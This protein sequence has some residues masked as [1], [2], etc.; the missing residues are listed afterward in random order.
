MILDEAHQLTDEASNALLKTLEE[1]PEHVV[2]ILATTRAEDL[3]DTINR[4]RSFFIFARS[5]SRKSPAKSNASPR[6]KIS[7]SIPA[8]SPCWRAPPKA[9][10]RDG[11]SLLEQAIAYC[12]DAIT[13]TQVRE[14][15]G[16]VAESVLDDLVGA[17]AA[18]SAERALASF[19][20]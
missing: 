20:A 17:I 18:Q 14:L 11:L 1:P 12:G 15:L 16:V 19:T 9:A 3:V 8:P 2:F 10:L 4:A 7:R 6:P 5:R 13:D